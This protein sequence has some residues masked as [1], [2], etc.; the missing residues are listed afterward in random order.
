M[1]IDFEAIANALV[2][3][4]STAVTPTGSKAL[5]KVSAELPGQIPAGPAIYVFPPELPFQYGRTGTRK[6]IARYRVVLYVD[7]TSDTKRNS[8]LLLRWQKALYPLIAAHLHLGLE[9]Y[10][11]QARIAEITPGKV[12]YAGMEYEG[13]QILV[14]VHCWEPMNA[15]A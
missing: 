2:T 13:L 10:V 4:F 7:Q 1:A 5:R 3:Q 9:T 11:N 12:Q 8:T 6:V 14:D 15:V